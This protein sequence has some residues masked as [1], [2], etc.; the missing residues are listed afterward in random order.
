[1]TIDLIS[2]L[3]G[4]ETELSMQK[5][6]ECAGCRGSGIDPSSKMSTCPT[7]GGSGR[8][9]VAEGPMHFTK[10]CPQCQGHGRT[11]KPCAGCG[12]SGH[13][14]GVEKIRVVIPQGVKEGSKVRV[15]GKGEPGFN[16]GQPGD[17]YMIIHVKPHPVL[18]REGD[19]LLIDVPVTVGE[20]MAGSTITIP[21]I[22]GKV[23][24]KI[25]PKSQNGQTLRL[26]G[27]GAVN[28][29]TKQ[30]GDL[31][32][33]LVVKVPQTDDREILE[34]AKKMGSFYKKDLRSDIRL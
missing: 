5:V 15:A 12:G 31:M 32:A 8:L 10:P 23:S 33:K 16:G 17:L 18:K 14:L 27:K 13:T 21:T 26:K 30:K 34:A 29:K 20:A 24:V 1:M 4:F 3:K 6:K 22:D 11:G 7:C 9:S 25:P 28:I 2:A 19:N